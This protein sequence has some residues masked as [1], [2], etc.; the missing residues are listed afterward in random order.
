MR[1]PYCVKDC[2][3]VSFQDSQFAADLLE[4]G[5]ALVEVL[6]VVAGGDLYADAGLA[7]RHHGVVEA[8]DVDALVLQAGGEALREGG[9]VEHDGADGALRGFDVETAGHHLVAEV[10]DVLHE[11][12]VEL[13]GLVEHLEGLEGCADDAGGHGV[14]E[15]V[16]AR[17]LAQ[18]VD[19]LLTAGGE[20][21]HG[22]AE[23]FAQGAGVD[24]DAAIGVV[25]LADAAAGLADDACGVALIDHDEGVVLLGEVADAVHGGDV[26]VHGED[27]VGHDD[28]EAL[29]L[30]GLEL[31]LEVVH[32]G[33]GVAVALGL[34]EAHAVDDAGVVE[35]VGDD[36]VLLGEQWLEDTAVGVEAGGVENG[37]LGVE[38][39]ADGGLQLLVDVL[40]A[41]D[42]AHA[43]H[44]VA[45]A[46]HH[47]LGALDEARVVAETQV[48]V[49]TEIQDFLAGYLDGGSLRALDEALVLVETGLAD[50]LQRLLEVLLHFS[51]H[52]LIL[53]FYV[54]YLLGFGGKVNDFLNTIALMDGKILL[55]RDCRRKKFLLS[56]ANIKLF[57]N[58]VPAKQRKLTN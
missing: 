41:A 19:D 40:G 1:L 8:G 15:E 50:F 32:V 37:V 29:F 46:V 22:A 18:E 21:A 57:H 25:E 31:A 16:R 52:K 11:A 43:G 3:V 47:P 51:V 58:F 36:G 30:G 24:I 27:A 55:K 54:G 39:A 33:V 17:A 6:A 28:A 34:A 45:A 48:V 2:T 14:G 44:A 9:V 42:E 49:G 26:A 12:V 23:G 7:L 13:V 38:E 53:R 5:D 4:G 20:A 10:G 35:G 56:S